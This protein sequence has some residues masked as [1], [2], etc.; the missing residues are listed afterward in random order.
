MLK[1]LNGTYSAKF[2]EKQFIKDNEDLLNNNPHTSIYKI[3]DTTNEFNNLN[4]SK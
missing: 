2:I 3:L 4:K 1:E